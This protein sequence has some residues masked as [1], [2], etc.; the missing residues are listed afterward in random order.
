MQC[1]YKEYNITHGDAME[2]G[3]FFYQ[4]TMLQPGLHVAVEPLVSTSNYMFMVDVA[5]YQPDKVRMDKELQIFMAGWHTLYQCLFPNFAA[6]RAGFTQ[7]C[8]C[9]DSGF[10]NFDS[11][12]TQKQI[13]E[14]YIPYPKTHKEDFFLNSPTSVNTL[15]AMFKPY[16][17]ERIRNAMHLGHKVRGFEGRRVDVLYKQPTPEDGRQRMCVK[18]YELTQLRFKNEASFSLEGASVISN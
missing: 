14:L 3:E 9:M 7:L 5:C 8:E 10:I 16:L 13:H 12:V 15:W 4:L 6:M 18:V 11:V 17:P 2:A 1:F